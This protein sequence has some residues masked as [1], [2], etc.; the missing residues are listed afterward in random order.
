MKEMKAVDVSRAVDGQLAADGNIIIRS[1]STDSEV[2]SLGAFLLPSGA[3]ASTDTAISG[4]HW[5]RELS[6]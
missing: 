1:V 5:T 2:L 3:N 4:R 6:L